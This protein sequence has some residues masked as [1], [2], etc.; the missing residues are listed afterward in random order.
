LPRVYPIYISKRKEYSFVRY[1]IRIVKDNC[2]HDDVEDFMTKQGGRLDCLAD[3]LVNKEFVLS[4]Y[5]DHS[6]PV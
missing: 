3:K 5:T 2:L 4:R 1:A 6:Y